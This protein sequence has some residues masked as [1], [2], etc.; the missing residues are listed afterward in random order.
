MRLM[1]TISLVERGMT[2]AEFARMNA[3][4]DEHTREQDN[5]IEVSDR[6]DLVATD[7]DAY[8]GSLHLTDLFVE[9]PYRGRHGL[10]NVH[11][12]V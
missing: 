2:D 3:G 12:R 11:S 9:K 8:D 4:F 10:L 6:H 7:G 5:P 1:D